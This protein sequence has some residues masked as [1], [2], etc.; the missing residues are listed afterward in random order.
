MIGTR[1]ALSGA[2]AVLGLAFVLGPRLPDPGVRIL[3][4]RLV[5]ERAAVAERELDDLHASL[6][7]GLGAVRTAA[8]GVVS[9]ADPP[10]AELMAAAGIVRGAE[11]G[12]P[13]AREAL[14]AL[15]AAARTVR[16]TVSNLE[17]GVA[18]GELTAIADQLATVAEPADAFAERRVA[19]TRLPA[20]LEDA[21]DA[22][23]RAALDVA[24]ALIDEARA[25]HATVAT[26]EAPPST[27]PVWIATTDAMITG[28]EAILDAARLDDGAAQVRAG[29]AFVAL[30][31]E[32]AS[33]DRAL[34]IAIGEA[35]QELTVAPVSRLAE[36][37]AEVEA[38]RN[39]VAAL[40]G[41]AGR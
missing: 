2:T 31:D 23:D 17:L 21:L 40:A 18:V 26:W 22:I 11:A 10:G 5:H 13:A 29:E 38:A 15:V 32:A 3:A 8:A 36:A 25:D 30:A 14:A 37:L 35:G 20:T 9:S 16:P 7:P 12:V 28:V 19:A 6:V 34:R 27:L 4:E 1:A 24:G 33:A 39:A 41:P